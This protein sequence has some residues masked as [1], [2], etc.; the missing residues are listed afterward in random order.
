M[1]QEEKAR[2]YDWLLEKH[3]QVEHQIHA[4][5]KRPLEATLQDLDSREY[6]P[7]NQIKVDALKQ[8]LRRID[9][10]VKRLF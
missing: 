6:T 7:E 10:D 1:N 3:Q 4:V 5:P 2:R 8:T 9:E